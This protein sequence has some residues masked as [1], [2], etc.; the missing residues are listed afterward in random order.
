MRII[1][2]ELRGRVLKSAQTSMLRPTTDRVRESVFNILAA[3]IDFDGLAVLDLFAG[4]GAL[5]IEA[6]SRGAARCDFVE[7]DR[8]AAAVIKENLS[9]LG[10]VGRSRVVQRDALKF[11]AESDA[12][13]DL[14]FADPPYAA[15]IFDRLTRDVVTLGRL[16]P[17]GLFVLE[18]SSAMRAL[19]AHG[20][21]VVAARTFG[22]TGILILGIPN[23]DAQC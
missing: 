2:G 23:D 8:K 13:Y 16:A 22:E 15:T 9:T 5:G 1:A 19:A 21:E 14:I 3:R 20:G 7:S 12:T 17:E 11:L 6:L 4:T 18:H 10:L